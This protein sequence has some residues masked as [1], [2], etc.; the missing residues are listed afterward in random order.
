MRNGHRNRLL[1]YSSDVG[2]PGAPRSG[3]AVAVFASLSVF[4]PGAAVIV[5]EL[6]LVFCWV[7][8]VVLTLPTVIS[9]LAAVGFSHIGWVKLRLDG[10][11]VLCVYSVCVVPPV[12][13]TVLLLPALRAAPYIFPQ[14]DQLGRHATNV[15]G[16]IVWVPLHI[17]VC[18]PAVHWLF[19]LSRFRAAMICGVLSVIYGAVVISVC[20][21]N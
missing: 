16:G 5:G 12:L 21:L 18:L 9:T 13:A 7:A 1:D 15:M 17:V 3:N 19:H 14:L 2:G 10:A 4:V 8:A 11:S 20:V 6:D